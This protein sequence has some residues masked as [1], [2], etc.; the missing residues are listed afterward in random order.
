VPRATVPVMTNNPNT[1][2]SNGRFRPRS[3]FAAPTAYDVYRNYDVYRDYDGYWDYEDD[4]PYDDDYY[5]R[6][7]RAP[8]PL[9]PEQRTSL[10]QAIDAGLRDRGCDN[11]LRAAQAWA[12]REKVRWGWLREALE[13]RGGFC[14]CEVVLN[15]FERPD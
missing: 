15:V 12:R 9:E 14:D 7:P 5:T 1:S 2:E 13:E 3:P 8:L 6:V 11:T 4:D 10:A